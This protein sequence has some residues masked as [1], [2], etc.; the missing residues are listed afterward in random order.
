MTT[1]V[2]HFYGAD[3]KEFCENYTCVFSEGRM[4]SSQLFRKSTFL[5]DRD[6]GIAIMTAFILI[7]LLLAG[8]MALDYAQ[9]SSE[10]IRMQNVADAA[11]LAAGAG[12]D[13]TN[14]AEAKKV[15]ETM[16][17]GYSSRLEPGASFEVTVSGQSL[18]VAFKGSTANPFMQMAGYNTT[19]IEVASTAPIPIKPKKLIFTPTKAQGWYYK[20]VSI[21]V[22]RPGTGA[23]ETVGTVTYQPQT[24]VDGGQGPIEVL[25]QGT[26]ELGDYSELVLQMDIKNDGCPIGY[27]AFVTRSVVKCEETTRT[28]SKTYDLTLRTDNPATSHYLF[29]DGVQ[30]PKGVVSPLQDILE[31]GKT[32]N[33]AWE[34]GGGFARQDFY[35]TAKSICEPNGNF[36]RLVK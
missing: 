35:Y 18:Q 16:L 14:P 1:D 22:R 2:N 19:A 29:V 12:Y 13:G 20:K 31:C 9:A 8:G 15:A 4:Q 30:L 21:I 36:V 23:L 11:V 33:H 24:Q 10:R 5:K 6:G 27:Q 34:D 26:L 3:H 7:P 25:P 32:A 28:P 17:N